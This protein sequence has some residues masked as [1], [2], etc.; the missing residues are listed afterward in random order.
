[1]TILIAVL[2][3]M[4]LIIGAFL[5]CYLVYFVVTKF[6]DWYYKNRNRF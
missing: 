6:V 5:P 4:A 3:G 1:M 2:Y